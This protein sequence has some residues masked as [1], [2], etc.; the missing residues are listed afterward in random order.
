M[1]ITISAVLHKDLPLVGLTIAECWVLDKSNLVIKYSVAR[2][3]GKRNHEDET[4]IKWRA[5]KGHEGAWPMFWH[6]S[7]TMVAS[8]Q[9]WI[10]HW[11]FKYG[12]W[13]FQ[14]LNVK[15]MYTFFLKHC[16]AAIS[17]PIKGLSVNPRLIC[18]NDLTLNS[19][20]TRSPFPLCCLFSKVLTRSLPFSPSCDLRFYFLSRPIRLFR[21]L[22]RDRVRWWWWHRTGH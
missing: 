15:M 16:S 10:F 11:N 18:A 17:W 13:I 5:G 4:C 12:R 22:R 14:Y 8:N 2:F 7:L 20:S 21:V 1:L 19:S 9:G 3:N 6:R